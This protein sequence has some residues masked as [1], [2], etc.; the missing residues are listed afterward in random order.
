MFRLIRLYLSFD[1]FSYSFA[2]IPF[3]FQI[4]GENLT[5]YCSQFSFYSYHPIEKNLSL[6]PP[7]SEIA[8]HSPNL[9][10]VYE[11]ILYGE[12]FEDYPP[13]N[14]DHYKKLFWNQTFHLRYY[15]DI[16]VTPSCALYYNHTYYVQMAQEPPP[17]NSFIYFV[18]AENIIAIS[19]IHIFVYGHAL[20]DLYPNFMVVPKYILDKSYV[21]LKSYNSFMP[22]LFESIGFPRERTLVLAQELYMIFSPNV[23]IFKERNKMYPKPFYYNAFIKKIAEHF[24]LR[25]KAP[26]LYFLANRNPDENR[27]LTNFDEIIKIVR[28]KYPNYKFEKCPHLSATK[29]YIILLDKVKLMWGVHT[30]FLFNMAYMQPKTVICELQCNFYL[31]NTNTM[32]ENWNNLLYF[33]L[34]LGLKVVFGR[35]MNII[36]LEKKQRGKPQIAIDMIG[37]GLKYL[38]SLPPDTFPCNI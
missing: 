29:D 2:F 31:P 7:Q 19:H 33:S 28:S 25:Q 32:N 3:H 10:N 8:I 14:L 4:Y 18:N 16:F 13:L 15:K 12:K 38:E 1:G 20:I 5:N 35:D 34:A 22:P 6:L 23:Y 26:H 11:P 30:S 17:N 36:W 24:H 27:F 21:P 9:E 37:I